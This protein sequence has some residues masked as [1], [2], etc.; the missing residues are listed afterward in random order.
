MLDPVGSLAAPLRALIHPTVDRRP[1]DSPGQL[2]EKR[3]Q[4]IVQTRE[5][6]ELTWRNESVVRAFRADTGL[7]EGG[8][9]GDSEYVDRW[10]RE[11]WIP[12]KPKSGLISRC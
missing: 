12:S 10:Q 4:H 8:T 7:V 9:P 11:A 2:P 5:A 1:T 3:G 6:I